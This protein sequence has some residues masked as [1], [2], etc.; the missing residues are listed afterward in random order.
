MLTK[1][2]PFLGWFKGY[3]GSDLRADA[4]A[5]LTVALVLIPQ[6]MAYAQ[7]AGLPAYYGL[8]AA[9]LPPMVA[10]LF[11]SSRQL[12]TG[13]VAVV[14]LMSAASLEPLATAGSTEFIAYAIILALVVGIFQLLLGILRLGLVVNFLSHPVINGFTNAAAIII[15][16]SQF[17]KFFGVYVDKAPHHYDT[18]ARVARAAM[19]YTHMPTLLYGISAVVI[20]VVLRKI[21]PRIPN[22]LIAVVTTTLISY[23]TGFN[24]DAVVDVSAI[25]LYGMEEKVAD[26][27]HAIAT[28]Q[29][30]GQERADLGNTL[31]DLRKA[32]KSLHSPSFD[33]T[34]M[35]GDVN[36]LTVHLNAAKEEAHEVRYE[37]RQMKFKAVKNGESYAFYP[38]DDVPAGMETEG[39]TWRISIKNAPLDTAKITVMG[40][41][42][43]VGKIPEGLPQFTVPQLTLKSFFKLLPTAIIISLLGFMEAIAIAKA[44]A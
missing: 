3:R 22:V 26:F 23:F 37:I 40:G 10:A 27:N 42:A 4:I 29:E 5:G 43:I 30:R 38:K 24:N 8:Y 16:S 18:M 2:F 19:D 7:L 6:S 9:F 1:V 20:M 21:N 17:S 33:Q 28:I 36:L 41:G 14:S 12:G 44:M 39:G 35:E 31:D 13:P 11:G 15:A 34:K 25:H 32:E